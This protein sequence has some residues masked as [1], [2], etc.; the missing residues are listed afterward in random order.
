MANCLIEVSISWF[1]CIKVSSSPST[2]EEL[3]P[4]RVERLSFT[5]LS[6][7]PAKSCRP[8]GLFTRAM[9][10]KILKAL[11]LTLIFRYLVRE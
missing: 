5:E 2:T 8:S 3:M 11:G 10:T 4:K 1:S 7:W 6:R 9:M